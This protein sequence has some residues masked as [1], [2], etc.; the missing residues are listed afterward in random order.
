MVKKDVKLYVP[1]KKEHNTLA[2]KDNQQIL[3]SK[4]SLHYS[5]NIKIRNKEYQHTVFKF[6]N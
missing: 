6:N 4:K 1:A 3:V 5:E 2:M